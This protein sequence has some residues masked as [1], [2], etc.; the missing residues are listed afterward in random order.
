MAEREDCG[1]S[2]CKGVVLLGP[3]DKAALEAMIRMPVFE[4]NEIVGMSQEGLTEFTKAW[5]KEFAR[6][7]GRGHNPSY[8][9]SRELTVRL[10]T[11]RK[12]DPAGPDTSGLPLRAQYLLHLLLPLETQDGIVGDLAEKYA[13]RVRVYGPRGARWWYWKQAGGLALHAVWERCRG[14]AKWG[15]GLEVL[16]RFFG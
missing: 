12:S 8:E 9:A 3:T 2:G 14:L 16:R 4:G 11:N 7:Y 10:L 5:H 1:R 15:V 6:I 13:A